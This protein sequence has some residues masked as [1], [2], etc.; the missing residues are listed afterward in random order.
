MLFWGGFNTVMEAT[1][2]ETFC[3]GC[4]EM[5]DNVFVELRSTIHY[6]NRS[7]VR[8][9]CSDCHVP[10]DWTDKIT[11]K[12]QASKEVWGKIF[13]TIDAREVPGQAARAGPARMG[14]TATRD[15][16]QP[17]A[18]PGRRHPRGN[19]GTDRAEGG[20]RR[21][22]RERPAEPHRRSLAPYRP[23]LAMQLGSRTRSVSRIQ[24]NARFR[25]HGATVL[26]R[27]SRR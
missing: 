3:T 20:G 19:T 23:E 6:T 16:A 12:M 25:A 17:A 26:L 18:H 10:H 24:P 9:M 7:G 14:A 8:A 1:N 5:R 2:T 4:H 22:R 27:I 11:R 15:R 13:R 21:E